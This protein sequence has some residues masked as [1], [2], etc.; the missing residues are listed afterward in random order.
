MSCLTK[1]DSA[2]NIF[3]LL[4]AYIF[5][6]IYIKKTSNVVID[7]IKPIINTILS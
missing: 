6:T 1:K 2:K 3:A 7:E 5:P 4:I